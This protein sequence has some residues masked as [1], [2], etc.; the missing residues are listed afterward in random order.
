M[1]D[2]ESKAV[3]AAVEERAGRENLLTPADLATPR[4]RGAGKPRPNSCLDPAEGISVGR[5]VDIIAMKL[6]SNCRRGG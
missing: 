3:I 4:T 6:G 5:L 1:S 2:T